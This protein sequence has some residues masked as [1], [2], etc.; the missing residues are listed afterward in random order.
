M[1]TYDELMKAVYE[2]IHRLEDGNDG[3][4]KAEQIVMNIKYKDYGKE[5]VDGEFTSCYGVPLIFKDIP[6][7]I[8]FYVSQEPIE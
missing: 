8:H 4:V 5:W 2:S 7:N 3:R 1:M 6:D